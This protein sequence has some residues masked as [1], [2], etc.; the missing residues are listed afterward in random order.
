MKLT[1]LVLPL[2]WL[3]LLCV[4]VCGGADRARSPITVHALDTTRGK[5]IVG[6]AVV[7]ERS[8]GKAWRELARANTDA[9]G[10]IETLLPRDKEVSAGVYRLTFETGAYY[11]ASKTKTFYPRVIIFFEITEPK[12]HYHVPLLL[13]PFGYST[14]RGS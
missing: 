12:E 8:D 2:S 10:R 9:D 1:H 13:S 7:L 6:M 11:A 3:A 5:P 4:P 14:Y